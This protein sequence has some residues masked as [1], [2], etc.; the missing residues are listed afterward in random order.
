MLTIIISIISFGII[1]SLSLVGITAVTALV[2]YWETQNLVAK[3]TNVYVALILLLLFYL[4]CYL[5]FYFLNVAHIKWPIKKKILAFFVLI[6]AIIIVYA[7]LTIFFF[8][9]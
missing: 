1:G 3:D 8:L 6:P 4:S 9:P 5:L 7:V 2:Q